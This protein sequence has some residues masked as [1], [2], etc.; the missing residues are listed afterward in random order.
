MRAIHFLDTLVT[1]LAFHPNL[2]SLKFQEERRLRK[3]HRGHFVSEI[4]HA[5]THPDSV[6]HPQRIGPH[7]CRSHVFLFH[8]GGID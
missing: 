5:I 4:T 2:K 8:T 3:A 7:Q 1:G 6:C